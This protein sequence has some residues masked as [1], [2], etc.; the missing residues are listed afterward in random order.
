MALSR[1]LLVAA[2]VVLAVA[3]IV[4]AEVYF[5]EQFNDDSW[6]DRWTVSTEWKPKS[7]MGKW[8]RT[9]GK[10]YGDEDDTGVQTSQDARFYGMSTDMKEFNNEGKDLVLQFSVK[11]EQ[12]IDCGG[13]YIKLLPGGFDKASFGGD[14]PYAIM[15]GPDICGT[16]T[17]RTHAI[18]S[19]KGKNLLVNKEIRCETDQLS[20]L[21]TLIIHAD[22]TY[23]VQI[24]GKSVQ[25]GSL[26]DHWDFL[27]PKKIKD[28]EVSKPD[29][30]VDEAKIPDPEATKPE[31]WD[32]TPATIPDPDAEKPDD[33]DDE[34]DGEWEPPMIDNPDYKGEWEAPMIDNPDY[35]GPWVHPEI[36]NP[37]YEYDDSVYNVC[38]DCAA[39]GFE[40]WQVKAG[41]IFDDILVTDSV[42]EAKEFADETFFAKQDE[43]KAMFDAAEEAKRKAEE[44][45]RKRRE[46][47]AKRAAEEAEEEEEDDDEDD[48]GDDDDYEDEDDAEL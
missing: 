2:A 46:E 34:D 41:S 8:V 43:E 26:Y 42:A 12:K 17:R 9:A 21:Y 30:W 18:L 11:H 39:V 6:E 1:T 27:A 45:E 24:D 31:D 48:E 7:E 22:N 40:L 35:K 44:E 36:D 14:T 10:W 4:S 28:P 25:E 19:Y 23:D 5:K 29:D 15:F 20:H 32:D 16:G 38:K 37:E 47:E 13:A 33:W 3:S